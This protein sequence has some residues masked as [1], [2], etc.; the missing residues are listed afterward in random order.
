[1]RKL[2]FLL[3]PGLT[4]FAACDKKLAVDALSFNVT[5]DSTTYHA[6]SN[7]KF[8]FEGDPT[9]ITFYSGEQGRQCEYCNRVSAAG[10]PTLQFSTALNSGAQT[11]SLL[12]MVSKDFEGVVAGDTAATGR[13]INKAGWTDRSEEHTSELQSH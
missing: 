3:V 2:L 1:M 11:G 9:I 8:T 10:I 13:N 6:G 5:P 7:V 12:L 4:V